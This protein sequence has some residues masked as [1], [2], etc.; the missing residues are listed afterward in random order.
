MLL[1]VYEI[2]HAAQHLA[3]PSAL[4]TR[5]RQ[6]ARTAA[7][8]RPRRGGWVA[9]ARGPWAGCPPAGRSCSHRPKPAVQLPRLQPLL[10]APAALGLHGSRPGPLVL[11]SPG[12][13]ASQTRSS[14]L[15]R[16]PAA[17]GASLQRR[18]Q[19][20]PG[21]AARLSPRL[22]PLLCRRPG[23]TSR[24]QA[25][26]WLLPGL[27]ELVK[28]AVQQGTTGRRLPRARRLLLLQEHRRRG[29]PRR[30]VKQPTALQLAAQRQ[31]SPPSRPQ[32]AGWLQ[33]WWH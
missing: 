26:H 7:A 30:Q 24:H 20:L 6:R 25:G 19:S 28:L 3:C 16:P 21:P 5:H 29:K 11:Q 27:L 17:A 14:P 10:R 15:L 32:A 1:W 23:S 9:T 18:M 2:Q 8:P 13:W 4:L 33:V 31:G 12:C 22:H